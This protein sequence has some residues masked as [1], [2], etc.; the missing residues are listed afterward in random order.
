MSCT[1]ADV[2]RDYADH[3]FA[4]LL[5]GGRMLEIAS[6]IDEAHRREC[7][8]LRADARMYRRLFEEACALD[9]APPD[10]DGVPC[11]MD[12]FVVLDGSAYLIVARSHRGKLA[13]RETTRK[14]PRWV[15]SRCVRHQVGGEVVVV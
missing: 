8:A 13:L 1:V 5:F 10:A 6:R 12:E 15:P 2:L 11:R 7:D 3:S 4:G 14:P 9:D